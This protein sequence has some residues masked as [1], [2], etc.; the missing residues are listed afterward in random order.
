M[1]GGLTYGSQKTILATAVANG[2]DAA[3]PRVM[4]YTNEATQ[5][6]LNKLTPVGGMMSANVTAAADGSLLLPKEMENAIDASLTGTNTGVR[7]DT[8]IGQV[9]FEITD[10]FTYLD[11][12]DAHDNPLIDLGLVPDPGPPP[13][14]TTL[15]RK[16]QYPGIDQ[17]TVVAIV[18]DKRYLPI[19]QDSDPL[20]VQNVPALKQVI[21]SIV[22][23]ENNAP[24]QDWVAR[25]DDAIN[26][27]KEEVMKFKMD[28]RN[29]MRRRSNYEADLK[30]FKMGTKGWIRAR[31]ALEQPGGTQLGKLEL[32]RLLE[33][34]E[35]EIIDM[36]EYK[37]TLE[38]FEA[39]V[40]GGELSFPARVSGIVTIKLNCQ[41]QYVRSIFFNY[42]KAGGANA[43][44]WTCSGWD[45]S[46]IGYVRDL[47]D[48]DLGD[49]PRRKYQIFGSIETGQ[50]LFAV[51]KL[52]WVPKQPNE[53]MV[54]RNIRAHRAMIDGLISEQAG[55][56]DE[57]FKARARVKQIMDEELE[58]Y[59]RGVE[60]AMSLADEGR[61]FAGL[62]RML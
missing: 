38:E 19:T 52:R 18:G 20:L 35:M 42:L 3:D 58:S 59:L 29:F 34:S 31:I 53:Y 27:L 11:P 47:G 15:R 16:Y 45:G 51:C 62:G 33:R 13:N 60:P 37:G 61:S 46:G 10:R 7:G 9:F 49:I 17:G 26:T 12:S 36:G 32:D 40:F 44:D 57:L 56:K 39:T 14:P 24:T 22:M 48:E 6:V 8:D 30:N 5:I 21:E 43:W 1:P 25:R 55:N 23:R 54:I 4:D 2:I 28:R 41:A 50:K